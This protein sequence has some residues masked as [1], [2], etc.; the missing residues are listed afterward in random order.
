MSTQTTEDEDTTYDEPMVLK[1]VRC[2]PTLWSQAAAKAKK[3]DE[4]LSRVIRR[5]LREYVEED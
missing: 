5:K 4:S 3:R 1:N 2:W